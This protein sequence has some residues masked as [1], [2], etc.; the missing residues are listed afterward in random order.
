MMKKILTVLM[1]GL[2]I[3]SNAAMAQN[4]NYVPTPVT[5]SKEKTKNAAGEVFYSHVVLE[6]QTLYSISKAYGV[7]VDEICAANKA[8][9]L[10][11]E[12]LKK[13]QIILIPVASETAAAAVPVETAASPQSET[14]YTLHTVKWFEDLS[15]IAARY[16]V[17]ADVIMEFNGMKS[18]AVTRRQQI[19][20]PRNYKPSAGPIATSAGNTGITAADNSSV[21]DNGK[22]NDSGSIWDDMFSFG[23]KDF[24][25]MSLILPLDSKGQPAENPYD[26]Y[27]GAL[28]AVRDLE[29]EG[30]KVRM[31]VFDC[32][33]G[34]MPAEAADFNRSDLVIGPVSSADIA[35][36]LEKCQ[37]NSVIVSPL[38]QK[39]AGLAATHSNMVHLPCSAEMQA[40]ELVSWL[41]EESAP[42]DKIILVTEKSVALTGNAAMLKA[43]MDSTHV[44]YTLLSY[45]ILEGRDVINRME[46]LSS[47][48]GVTRVVIASES[49]A[50]VNDAIRNVSLLNVRKH[51]AVS[52]CLAKVRNFDT[53]DV[54]QFHSTRMHICTQYFVDYSESKVMD[55]LMTYRA[56]YNAEPGPFAFQGY[57]STYLMV[58][59]CAEN[60][61]NWSKKL[62]GTRVHG[63]QT[64][65]SFVNSASGSAVNTAV[66]RIIYD[67]GYE[68][69]LV[70]GK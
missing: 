56:L 35:N 52:Y 31:D 54:E 67:R 4:E 61:R 43:R 9:H 64:D 28:V 1:I 62:S 29:A 12:G 34:A 66:R 47:K 60:G 30:I 2:G 40:R 42:A 26:F 14:E 58:K 8:L 46:N 45:G 48:D 3:C 21:A 25:N 51:D 36:A 69:R 37:E 33:H 24:V 49:E 19:K 41:R 63:L 32:A 55:F 23:R 18:P 17:P 59:A 20:I 27:C 57:D 11:T 70:N 68:I 22:G 7:S 53:I 44:N 13:N 10:D 6:R 65:L 50:F 5:V 38:E 15:S 39:A 16:G